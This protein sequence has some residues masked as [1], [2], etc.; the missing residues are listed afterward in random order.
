MQF[1]E[2]QEGAVL[3]I[4][5][6]EKRLDAPVAQEFKQYMAG[7]VEAGHRLIA[8]DLGEVEFVDSSGLSGIIS[9][10]KAVGESGNVAIFGAGSQVST[11]FRLTRMDRI[12]PMMA[13]VE[14]ALALLI[15]VCR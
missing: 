6:L 11:L 15:P 8:L 2:R 12:F 1:E 3:V 13:G 14:E 10:L 7:R 9:L 5:P 4:R